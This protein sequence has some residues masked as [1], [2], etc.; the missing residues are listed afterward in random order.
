MKLSKTHRVLA[1]SG[2]A[3]CGMAAAP[4]WGQQATEYGAITSLSGGWSLDT[5]AVSHSGRFVN[6]SG[7]SLVTNGYATDPGDPGH[8]LFHT[9][10]LAAFLNRK[11]VSLTVSGCVFNK[12]KIIAVTIR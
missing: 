2:L 9:L 1:A 4:A 6:P 11:E 7:C 12:P 8:S 10:A 3:A 5:L